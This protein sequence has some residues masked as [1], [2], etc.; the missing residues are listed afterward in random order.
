MPTRRFNPPDLTDA[1]ESTVGP[2]TLALVY[3][4]ITNDEGPTVHIFGPVNGEER[5]ILRFDCF[6]NGPH[7]H[8]GISYLDEPVTMIEST[9]PLA[10]VLDE[11][12]QRFPDYLTASQI[13]S[14]LPS[15]WQAMTASALKPF[16]TKA[17]EWSS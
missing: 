14:E 3:R 4:H 9:D 5:E 17:T 1:T 10:W 13:E 2:Y 12:Q 16:R 8:K 7:Y 6:R 15:D 11:L